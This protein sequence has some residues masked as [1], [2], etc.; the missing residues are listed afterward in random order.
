M[1]EGK[2]IVKTIMMLMKKRKSRSRRCGLYNATT[3]RKAVPW[4]SS[5]K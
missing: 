3:R 2:I 5:T 4:L 1:L